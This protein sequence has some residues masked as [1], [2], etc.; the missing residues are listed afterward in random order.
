[1]TLHKT[2]KIAA[3]MVLAMQ[4]ARTATKNQDIIAESLNLE[5]SFEALRDAFNDFL[6]ELREIQGS[7]DQKLEEIEGQADTVEVETWRD[8]VQFTAEG[9]YFDG[10][11]MCDLYPECV[12][13]M[14]EQS[15]P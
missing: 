3:A 7:R 1:M 5:A 15:R 8:T 6:T 4:P 11:S 9:T 2:L 14:K 10:Y 13:Q 12:Q